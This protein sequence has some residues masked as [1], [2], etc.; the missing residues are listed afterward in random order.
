MTALPDFDL[1]NSEVALQ[2]KPTADGGLNVVLE[3][4]HGPE[5][6]V[7]YFTRGQVV[8]ALAGWHFDV[9]DALQGVMEA[10]Q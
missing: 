3:S 5:R 8:R 10:G 2:L 1:E 4:L 9:F 6:E 7:I